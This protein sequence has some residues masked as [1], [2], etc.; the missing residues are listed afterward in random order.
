MADIPMP[1]GGRELVISFG[2]V[3]PQVAGSAFVAAGARL[4]G[5]VT[6][7]E[8]ASVWFNAVLRGDTEPITVGRFTNVQDNCTLHA[9]PGLPCTVGD[10]VTI[11]HGAVVHGCTVEDNVLIGMHATILNGAVIGR[12]TIVGAA[13]LVPERAQIPPGSLVLGVPGRVVRQLRPEEIASIRRS[14]EGY[15]DRAERYRTEIDG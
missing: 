6:V 2:G 12:D 4:I 5:A 8:G 9:D 14:A 11:G 13:A 3:R 15:A 7:G 10:Y 1:N